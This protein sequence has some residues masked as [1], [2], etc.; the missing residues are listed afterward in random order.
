MPY[1]NKLKTSESRLHYFD[2][3]FFHILYLNILLLG[4]PFLWSQ[5]VLSQHSLTFCVFMR[6]IAGACEN[7]GAITHIRRDCLER[8]RKI[9]A[10][11]TS[12]N[13]APDEFVQPNLSLTVDGKRDRWNG[14]DNFAHQV[15][16]CGNFT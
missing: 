9:G 15:T 1:S 3:T 12:S 14:Y 2:T 11:F 4:L 5:P 8:P 13:F 7:C 6:F 16:C 10:K